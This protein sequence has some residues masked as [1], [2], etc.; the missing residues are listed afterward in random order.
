[1]RAQ[2]TAR[3]AQTAEHADA[4]HA[5]A[6]DGRSGAILHPRLRCDAC[7]KDGRMPIPAAE[8][9]LDGG[10]KIGYLAAGDNDRVGATQ[11]FDGLPQTAD[12]ED[13]AAAERVQRVDQDQIE[14]AGELYVLKAVVEHHDVA[15][16]LLTQDSSGLVTFHADADRGHAGTQ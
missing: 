16:E 5:G 10:R 2:E 12:R 11:S 3:I 14:I 7:A 15:A 13:F 6:L 4:F 8:L 1:Q 9:L